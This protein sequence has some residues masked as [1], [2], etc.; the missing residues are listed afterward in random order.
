M[1]GVSYL[2]RWTSRLFRLRAIFLT[3]HFAIA[4]I[5]RLRTACRVC[6]GKL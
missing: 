3:T 2:M 4:Y 5:G 6:G 1:V